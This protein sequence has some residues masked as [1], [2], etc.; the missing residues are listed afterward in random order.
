MTV[1][2]R[3]T[4]RPAARNLGAVREVPRPGHD[5]LVLGALLVGF[6]M[7]G[8]QLWLL[9]VATELVLE[10]HASAAWGPVALSGVVLVG[11]LLTEWLLSRARRRSTAD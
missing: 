9:S 6:M 3:T 1:I 5:A 8:L 11:G 7:I 4:P 2:S 10:G